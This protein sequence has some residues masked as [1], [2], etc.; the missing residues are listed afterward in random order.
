MRLADGRLEENSA[1]SERSCGV[2]I[3]NCQEFP[4]TSIIESKRDAAILSRMYKGGGNLCE[5]YAT[6][7][8]RANVV[9]SCDT[10]RGISI[11]LFPLIKIRNLFSW[12]GERGTG[13]IN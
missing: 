7:Y 5:R 11:T 4:A 2:K 3:T 6:N 10:T 1:G 12:R 8:R 13:V 9:I